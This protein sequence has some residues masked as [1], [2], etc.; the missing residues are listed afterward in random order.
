MEWLLEKA[1]SVAISA[2]KEIIDVYDKD[3]DIDTKVDKSPLTIAD[4]RANT[5]IQNQLREIDYGIPILSE[6]SSKEVFTERTTWQLFWLVDP[7]DGTKEFVKRNWEFTV[8][9]ALIDTGK[10]ILGVVYN[11]V[12]E[13]SYYAAFGVG[14]FKC[15]F[16]KQQNTIRI[17]KF[18]KRQG[19]MVTSRSHYS[20]VVEGYRRK[21]EENVNTLDVASIGSSLKI[22]LVAEGNVDIYPRLGSTFEWDTAAAHCVLSVAGGKLT[23]INGNVLKYN[24]PNILNP[25]FL[26]GGDPNVD[27][28]KFLD[29]SEEFYLQLR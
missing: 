28:T 11:P 16:D 10:P 14:A 27:W 1:L 2:G 20:P 7:L 12:K 29:T 24:K 17:R 4:K 26:A 5:L 3:F 25:W 18:D 8:N 19:K 22:C 21:L 9:I 23:D 15:A 6:E 13:I